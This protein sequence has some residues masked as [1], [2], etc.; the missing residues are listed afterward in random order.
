MEYKVFYVLV[1]GF[2]RVRQLGT[3][4]SMHFSLMMIMFTISA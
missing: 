1:Q 3:Q 4:M 2:I